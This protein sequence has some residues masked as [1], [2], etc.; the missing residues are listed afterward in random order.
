VKLLQ[1]KEDLDNYIKTLQ[2]RYAAYYQYKYADDVPDIYALQKYLSKN[3]QAFVHYFISD[4]TI[5]MLGIT[6]SSS[7]LIKLSR[8]Q[9]NAKLSHFLKICS[10]KQA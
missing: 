3:K 1:A 10:D 5:Y 9:F 4:T 2:D 7:K 6:A 8:Q